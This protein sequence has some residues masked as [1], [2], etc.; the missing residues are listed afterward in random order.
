VAPI[1][2]TCL[3]IKSFILTT[4]FTHVFPRNRS[5]NLCS[6][7]RDCSVFTSVIKSSTYYTKSLNV[8]IWSQFDLLYKLRFTAVALSTLRTV[9]LVCLPFRHAPPYGPYILCSAVGW[10]AMLQAGRLQVRVPMRWM[11]SIDLILS[12]ALWPWGRLSL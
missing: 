2:T 11:F 6:S 8:T 9:G 7:I 4:Y 12:A 1:C 10:G 3:N 5:Q